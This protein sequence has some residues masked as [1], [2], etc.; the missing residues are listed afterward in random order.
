MCNLNY[1]AWSHNITYRQ[2]YYTFPNGIFVY[3]TSYLLSSSNF[4]NCDRLWSVANIPVVVLEWGG[5][6]EKTLLKKA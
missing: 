4:Q 5:G 6:G 3:F 2:I 1:H